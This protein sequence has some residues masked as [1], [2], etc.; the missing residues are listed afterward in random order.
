MVAV[1]LRD[2]AV[3]TIGFAVFLA[4]ELLAFGIGRLEPDTRDP[5]TVMQLRR[6]G[7]AKPPLT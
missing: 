3:F 2:A 7:V 5:V 4:V 1:V 6:Y